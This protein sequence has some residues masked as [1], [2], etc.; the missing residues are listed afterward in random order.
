MKLEKMRNLVIGIIEDSSYSPDAI[1]EKLSQA[2]YYCT[3]IV[4]IP[5][6]KRIF[7]IQTVVGQSYLYLNTQIDSFSGRVKRIKYDGNTLK[8]YSTLEDMFD[9]YD[10][11]EET[12]DIEAAAL[13][14]R[15]LWYTKVPETATDLT[16]ICYINPE[17]LS[18]TNNEL[19][20]MP[21][22]IQQSVL[23]NGAV[24]YIF[25]EIEEEDGA[26]PMA[27]H[28]ESKMEDGILDFRGWIAKN[29][30]SRSYNYWSV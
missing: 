3:G 2:L 22:H 14:G 9:D 10:D 1:S 21:E 12:G 25:D 6:F 4:D 27:R 7:P 15:I 17:P 16:V 20:W 11:L 18:I 8:I 28:Y 30:Q 19:A 26:K 24:S 23:I 29:R 13:E 5:E